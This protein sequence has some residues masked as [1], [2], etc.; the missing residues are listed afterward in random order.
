MPIHYVLLENPQADD[1]QTY[2]AAVQPVS[3][4][5]LEDV[6]DRMVKTAVPVSR[7]ELLAVLEGFFAAIERMVLEGRHVNTP[8]ANFQ[9]S[10][11]GLFDSPD[12]CYD[13]RRHQVVATVSPGERFRRT[14]RRQARVAK[15]DASSVEPHPVQLLDVSSGECNDLLTPGGIGRLAG[16]QLKFNP[17]DPEQGIFFVAADGGTS[18][19]EFVGK[20]MPA[21][22]RFLIPA[23]EPGEY[24]LQVRAIVYGCGGVRSGTLKSPLT[25]LLHGSA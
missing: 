25:V 5:E 2:Q 4:A 21:E 1:L 11:A 9:A 20:N 6:I 7:S 17:D 8:L 13:P 10:I 3:T 18:R 16:H 24:R 15:E 23:L 12:D 14:I 19:V 22:L